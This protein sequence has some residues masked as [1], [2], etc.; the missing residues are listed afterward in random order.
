MMSQV[1]NGAVEGPQLGGPGL[2]RVLSNHAVPLHRFLN[3]RFCSFFFE[4]PWLS[5]P[6]STDV[7]GAFVWPRT[8]T[9]GGCVRLP[10]MPVTE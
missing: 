3:F 10:Q 7:G 4:I 5:R 8:S 1:R 9:L 6:P 2:K